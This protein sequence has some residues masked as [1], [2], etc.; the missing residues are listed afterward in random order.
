[1][2]KS[3]PLGLL[4]KVRCLLSMVSKETEIRNPKKQFLHDMCYVTS[5]FGS[6][7]VMVEMEAW[8]FVY[9]MCVCGGEVAGLC[10]AL[11]LVMA[12]MSREELPRVPCG[13]SQ[14]HLR[15]PTGCVARSMEC[16]PSTKLRI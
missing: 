6:Y 16:R 3:K 2:L 1:M 4:H 8:V 12:L 9:V 7:V 15:I 5:A 11:Q 10:L 14:Q 13:F